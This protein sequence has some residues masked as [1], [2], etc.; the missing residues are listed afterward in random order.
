MKRF[1]PMSWNLADLPPTFTD[2]TFVRR[3]PVMRANPPRSARAT[4][5][6]FEIAGVAA[7]VVAGVVGGADG[8]LVVKSASCGITGSP[9]LQGTSKVLRSP[10]LS[11]ADP[12]ASG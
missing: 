6:T 2:R 1:G 9:K 8:S 4:P 10:S 5:L 7:G 3:E 12:S 11:V